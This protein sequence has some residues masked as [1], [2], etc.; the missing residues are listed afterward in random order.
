MTSSVESLLRSAG[1]AHRGAV[2]W[3]DPVPLTS[4][5]VYLVATGPDPSNGEGAAECAIDPAAVATL[6]ERRPEACVDGVAADPSSVTSRLQSMWVPEEPVLYI[7]LAGTS[8]QTRVRQYY[9]TEIGARAPHA[10]GW[11]IKMLAALPDLWV[12]YGET[13]DPDGAEIA[14]IDAFVAGV[15]PTARAGL[16]D[17]TAPLPF[18]NLMYPTGR[19]KS[20]GFTG[21]KAPR[22]AA[23][24]TP[25]RP[26]PPA[27][28]TSLITPRPKPSD[29]RP[30]PPPVR[31]P[32]RLGGR[33]TQNVTAADISKGQIRVPSH[34]KD[35]LPRE[36]AEIDVILCGEPFTS[37]WNPRMGPDKE[38]SGLIRIPSARLAQ[39]VRA[40]G[41]LKII[42]SGD[43]YEI[44]YF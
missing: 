1:V 36:A 44:G 28:H 18:A 34:S 16:V 35:I 10:G 2:R 32:A 3:G 17:P 30:S 40:G 43:T 12:H 22:S 29:T 41:P 21:V 37:R 42:R 5:G 33:P 7:G 13:D 9:R 19:R 4:S 25:A 8:L 38:R 24:T 27:A 39:L 11:P 26:A 23:T 6:L 20:H 15:D 14:M 31:G